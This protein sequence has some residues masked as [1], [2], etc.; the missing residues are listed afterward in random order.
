M[1]QPHVAP[2]GSWKSPITSDLIVSATVG[3]GQIAL[4]GADI[5][6]VEL[7]PSEGGRNCIV[8][9]TPDGAVS[10]V[11]PQGFNA[12]TRVHEYGGGD[13]AVRDGAVYFSNFADQRLYRQR[14]ETAPQA[15]TPE[16]E[17][18]YSDF[19]VDAPRGRLYAVREDHTEEGTEAVNTIVAARRGGRGRA[20]TAGGSS[21]RATTSTRRRV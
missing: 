13:F 16:G 9:Q 10:D 5:Y 4:D 11:T 21:F 7:R 2:Y 14:T 18:R 6:W 8:R 3:L 1:T 19:V 12:R 17:F 20:K 15:F